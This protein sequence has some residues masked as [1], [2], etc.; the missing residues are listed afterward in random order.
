MLRIVLDTNVLVSAIIA[1]G[2]PR[3]LLSLAIQKQYLLITS[4]PAID[5]FTDV[6]RRPKFRMTKSEIMRAKSALMTTGKIVRVTSKRKLV[7]EDP[8]DD[9]LINTASR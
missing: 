6:L 4:T 9:I 5:E 1:E 2:K 7:K 8:D 3:D